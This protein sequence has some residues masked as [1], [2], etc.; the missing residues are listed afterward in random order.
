MLE[1]AWR[2]GS[3][4]LLFFLPLPLSFSLS[5]FSL[6]SLLSAAQHPPRQLANGIKSGN[7]KRNRMRKHRAR[8]EVTRLPVQRRKWRCRL[9]FDGSAQFTRNDPQRSEIVLREVRDVVSDV[10]GNRNCRSY[11]RYMVEQREEY[12]TFYFSTRISLRNRNIASQWN[13]ETHCW[14]NLSI[15]WKYVE[16]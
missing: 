1:K 4:Y 10:D 6:S 2:V 5:S 15:Y 14:H 16:Y 3:N 9:P 7:G 11:E 8:P 12:A 13:T